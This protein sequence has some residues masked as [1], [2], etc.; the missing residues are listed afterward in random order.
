M[1]T[2]SS[3]LLIYNSQSILIDVL[4]YVSVSISKLKINSAVCINS[5]DET[6]WNNLLLFVPNCNEVVTMVSTSGP[7]GCTIGMSYMKINK[8]V[9]Q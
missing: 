4:K 8:A 6:C 5:I 9:S 2:L 3:H 1:F 7:Y